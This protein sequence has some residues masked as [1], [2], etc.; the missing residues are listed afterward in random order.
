MVY[1]QGFHSHTFPRDYVVLTSKVLTPL[2]PSI[3][4]RMYVVIPL[5]DPEINP[6]RAIVHLLHRQE[7]SVIDNVSQPLSSYRLYTLVGTE[8]RS[9]EYRTPVPLPKVNG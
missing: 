9:G 8:Q 4:F 5:V 1:V 3:L 2:T 6:E 7:F